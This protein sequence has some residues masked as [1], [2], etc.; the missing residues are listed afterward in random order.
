MTRL[1]LLIARL[2]AGRRTPQ[3][4]F[5]LMLR[6]ATIL[7]PRLRQHW[8]DL[9]WLGDAD[10]DAYLDRFGE[11]DGLNTHRR[12][13]L[14][15]LLRLADRVPGDTA[16][17]GVYQG[18]AS[19]LMCRWGAL[20]GRRH[21]AIDSYAG[22]PQPGP[23][24]GTHWKRGDLS[25]DL[26]GVRRRLAGQPGFEPVRGWIPDVLAT[27]PERRYA[28]VHIDVDLHEPTLASIAYF[29]PRTETGGLILCDDYGSS[30]CPGATQAIDG[31][32]ADKPER[33][34]SLPCGG[35][36]ILRGLATGDARPVGG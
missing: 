9:D 23:A 10:F 34:V 24:D 14:W 16:E 25:A 4:R 15:Q 5:A 21:I 3:M 19:Y 30:L 28:A 27:L 6:L 22:L 36:F 18:A 13:T 29:Y 8:P 17:C 31:F 11:R 2:Y 7:T 12:F 1:M 20:R 32:L 33:M 26:D 35:G